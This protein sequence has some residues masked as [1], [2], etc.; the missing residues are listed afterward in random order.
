MAT[1]PPVITV[2]PTAPSR[3][4]APS[5]FI[6]R[7]DAFVAALIPFVSETNSVAT[8]ISGQMPTVE[9]AVGSANAA[10]ASAASAAASAASAVASPGTSATSTTNVLIGTGTKTFTVQTGKSFVVGMFMIAYNS[11]TNWMFGQVTAYNSGTGQL[12][13]NV[14]KTSGSGTFASWTIS[15][16]SPNQDAGTFLTLKI[17]ANTTALLGIHYLVDTS[18]GAITV[19][20]PTMSVS[21]YPTS[22]TYQPTVGFVDLK[23]TF[24]TNSLTIVPATG[25]Q[26]M[27]KPAN[28]TLICQLNYD[29]FVMGWTGLDWR[30][31]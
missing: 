25:Q 11:S 14:S 17:S 28:E 23:G 13:I 18:A 10:A 19:T 29:S 21:G 1:S 8:W 15:L 6:T 12:D 9:S 26:I 27:G 3:S 20:L 22:N 16:T 7:A 24:A 30:F 5:V 31:F 4:D 2:L